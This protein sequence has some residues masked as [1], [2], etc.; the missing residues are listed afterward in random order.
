MIAMRS[1]GQGVDDAR[2]DRDPLVGGQLRQVP[3][4]VGPVGVD[5]LV[6]PVDV[7]AGD[8]QRP[9]P[10]P[11]PRPGVDAASPRRTPRR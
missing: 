5:H 7:V 11:A 6:D 10:E 2:T 3:G 1:S 9:H 8:V 4:D